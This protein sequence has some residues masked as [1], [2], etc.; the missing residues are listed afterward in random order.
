MKRY[1]F[2]ILS[3]VII[4]IGSLLISAFVMNKEDIAPEQANEAM[5]SEDKALVGENLE[6]ELEDENLNPE[7][8]EVI[9]EQ[10]EQ[11]AEHI[12]I[13]DESEDGVSTGFP[14]VE[15]G[16]EDTAPALTVRALLSPPVK[17]SSD[18]EL[19]IGFVTDPH[20][21]STDMNGKR[22]IGKKYQDRLNYFVER[23]NNVFGPD[24]LIANGDIIEGTRQTSDI[25]RQEL[26]A[27]KSI[28]DRTSIPTYWVLGNH[29]LRAV[30][31][32]QW[33]NILG[34]DY[35]YKAFDV[36]QYRIF[37]L[38]S[39][40]T[41][42]DEDVI[43]GKQFTRGK[44]S[45]QQLIWLEKELKKTKKKPIIFMHHPPL[46]DVDSKINGGLLK[47]ANEVRRILAE[48]GVFAVFSGHIE[49]L[50]FEETN[51]VKYFVLPGLV[52][53]PD[54]QGTFAEISASGDDIEVDVSYLKKDGNYRTLQMKQ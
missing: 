12:S 16:K 49:D 34:I 33:K 31:K 7:Q 41:A 37:I 52:K 25:G 44:V 48:N 27:V 3:L 4:L 24:L 32:K 28:F 15:E 29:D 39:N 45:R 47:N 22:V 50:Y 9:E 13:T 6:I 14:V 42:Q 35:E 10:L 51:G 40:F 20:I 21:M 17:K 26:L 30:T 18:K 38:D 43:P 53:H 46:R 54:Y 11:N 5:V 2:A 8:E 19:R 23:M 36:K 1:Y